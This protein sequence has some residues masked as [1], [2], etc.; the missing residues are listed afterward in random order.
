MTKPK[1]DLVEEASLESFPA[2]DSPAWTIE[3]VGQAAAGLHGK[4][5]DEARSAGLR[6]GMHERD[7]RSS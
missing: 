3:S 5:P 2:S 4:R 1:L 6:A 7:D